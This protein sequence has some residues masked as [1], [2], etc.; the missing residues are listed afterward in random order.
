[1][2]YPARVQRV[3]DYIEIHLMDS[4][5]IEEIARQA[6]LSVPHLY[7]IFPMMTNAI[8]S[9][10]FDYPVSMIDLVCAWMYPANMPCMASADIWK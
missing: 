4:M 3:I 7:R 10:R 9:C 1:L 8:Y 5:L 6:F 2:E